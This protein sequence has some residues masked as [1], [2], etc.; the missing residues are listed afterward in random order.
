MLILL[1]VVA[2]G[3]IGLWAERGRRD[4]TRSRPVQPHRI[5]LLTEAVGYI[6]AILVLAGIS[7]AIGQRWEDISTGGRLAILGSVT[8]ILLGIGWLIR[9]SVEPALGRLAAVTWAISVATF[10]GSAAVVNQIYDTS[11]KA[12]YVTIATST[13][14]YASALWLLHRHPIQ[15]AV[16]FAGVLVATASVIT[17]LVNEPAGW[18]IAVPLWAIGVGWAAAGWRGWLSPQLVAVPLGLLV[19]LVAPSGIGLSGLRYGLG[20]STAAAVMALSVATG[21]TLALALASVAMLGYV[22]GSVTYYFGDT[23][24]VPASL[25]VAGIVILAMAAAAARWHWFGKKRPPQLPPSAGD[26]S[27]KLP[28][29]QRVA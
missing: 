4:A 18:M 19:A 21:F 16:T 12:A 27:G 26:P 17:W 24:G 7:V 15:H 3:G 9:E 8:A 25:A 22:I 14:V 28:D 1:A 5:S 20:L 10:A 11:D 13:A 23:L 6:G 2:I 29:Q